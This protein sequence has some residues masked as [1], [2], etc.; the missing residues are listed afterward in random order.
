MS[1]AIQASD[2]RS[3]VVAGSREARVGGALLAVLPALTL[4][5]VFVGAIQADDVATDF[6]QFYGAAS[7]ILRGES[8]YLDSVDSLTCGGSVSI[9][10]ASCAA[11]DPADRLAARGCRPARHG[12]ARR[13]R[14]CRSVDARRA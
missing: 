7:A 12:R 9:S 8:P 14:P 2:K 3:D 6:R 5:L 13:C 1:S 4:C 10:A 11:R